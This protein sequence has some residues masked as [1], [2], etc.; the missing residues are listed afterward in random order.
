MTTHDEYISVANKALFQVRSILLQA[1]SV[2]IDI[3]YTVV[4]ALL[5]ESSLLN[6]Q[7]DAWLADLMTCVH[8]CK[9]QRIA[10]VMDEAVQSTHH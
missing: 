4:V 9:A 7:P 6:E 8:E 5:A 1:Q 3:P 10:S 2:D